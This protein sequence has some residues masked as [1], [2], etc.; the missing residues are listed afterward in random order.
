MS[1]KIEPT[2]ERFVDRA[3]RCLD[4]LASIDASS[5]PRKPMDE[6]RGLVDDLV[7]ERKEL[8]DL[9]SRLFESNRR[10][11][12]AEARVGELRNG[13]ERLLSEV[14]GKRATFRELE[15]MLRESSCECD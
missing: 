11:R 8:S 1:E 15:A 4:A 9:K 6:L 5:G 3:Q 2:S 12:I 7:P 13:I 14:P 10:R